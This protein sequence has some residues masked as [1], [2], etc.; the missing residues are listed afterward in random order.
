MGSTSFCCTDINDSSVIADIITEA[1]QN[2]FSITSYKALLQQLTNNFSFSEMD[3]TL[4]DPIK[5]SIISPTSSSISNINKFLDHFKV[6]NKPN[7]I[8]C[9]ELLLFSFSITHQ[10]GQDKDLL[11]DFYNL[12]LHYEK[13]QGEKL[14][15]SV[16]RSTLKIILCK[17]I[18]YSTQFILNILERDL[19]MQE[20][21]EL[22]MNKFSYENI[23]NFAD[24]LLSEFDRIIKDSSNVSL[25][26]NKNYFFSL[27]DLKLCFTNYKFIFNVKSL[28]KEFDKFIDIN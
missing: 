19:R 4:F 13:K 26:C 6:K 8:N 7:K 3:L 1:S 27:D 21:I 25:I 24:Y 23:T 10:D 22:Y 15:K 11:F 9:F 2:I 17:I 16:D 5:N 20:Y 14:S 28:I 12:N 18:F